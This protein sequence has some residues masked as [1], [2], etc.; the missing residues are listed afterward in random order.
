MKNYCELETPIGI[1]TIIEENNA[2]TKIVFG[3]IEKRETMQ[4]NETPLLKETKKQ[5]TEYFEGTRNEFQIPCNPKGTE[6]QK[7][8]WQELQNIP[9]GETSTYQEIAFSI[10][11]VRACRSVGRA[12]NKNP[13][14]IIIPCHRVIGK[15]NKLLGYAGGMQIKE[16]LLR[17]EGSQLG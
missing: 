8:V 5:L 13:I 12:N 15:N 4:E 9:Y 1:L 16:F 2:I 10:G 17:L 6:F 11:N 14:P 3:S 7:D